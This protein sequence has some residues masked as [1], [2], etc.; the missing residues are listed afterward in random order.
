MSKPSSYFTRLRDKKIRAPGR[1]RPLRSQSGSQRAV[2]E[3]AA[4]EHSARLGHVAEHE[5]VS[6]L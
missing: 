3:D 2:G 1:R 4:K 5:P 6:A